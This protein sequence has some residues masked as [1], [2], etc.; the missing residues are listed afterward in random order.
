MKVK[1]QLEKAPNTNIKNVYSN[2][3]CPFDVG[4]ILYE[5]V[6]IFT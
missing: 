6:L 5:E 2:N 1:S 3:K 4:E